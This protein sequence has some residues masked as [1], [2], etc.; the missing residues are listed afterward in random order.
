[1]L[2]FSTSYRHILIVIRRRNAS[3]EYNPKHKAE[4]KT[5]DLGDRTLKG[6]IKRLSLAIFIIVTSSIKSTGLFLMKD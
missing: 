1:M 4:V 5:L 3:G 6:A 2:T